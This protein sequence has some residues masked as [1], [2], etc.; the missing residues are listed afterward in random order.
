MVHSFRPSFHRPSVMP[1]RIPLAWPLPAARP[2]SGSPPPLDLSEVGQPVAGRRADSG[3]SRPQERRPA[4]GCPRSLPGRL[5]L[6]T[7]PMV[8]RS[9]IQAYTP[10][11]PWSSISPMVPRSTIQAY[12]VHA[13][14]PATPRPRDAAMSASTSN[15]DWL[16]STKGFL[17]LLVSH[18]QHVRSCSAPS[19]AVREMPSHART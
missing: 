1:S 10:P 14:H 7:S 18:A 19:H 13:R 2:P 16:P 8:P 15:T 17:A 4:A 12:T 5:R 9:T 11:S 6:G 3:E